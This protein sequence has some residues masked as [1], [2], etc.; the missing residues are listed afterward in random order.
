[1]SRFYH[2]ARYF[3]SSGKGMVTPPVAAHSVPRVKV[4]INGVLGDCSADVPIQEAALQSENLRKGMSRGLFLRPWGSRAWA[5]EAGNGF[6]G[7]VK[8]PWRGGGVQG[9]PILRQTV[10]IAID[11]AGDADRE[12]CAQLMA[13]SEPWVTL[14]HDFAA[15]LGRCRGPEFVAL[16][17]RRAGERC[18]FVLLDPAGVAG[19]R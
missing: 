12:W 16:M 10:N 7:T 5:F 11:L 6:P 4:A 19:S 8:H 13:S 15:C 3:N 2:H 17:A 18:G 9:G 1:M 14:G